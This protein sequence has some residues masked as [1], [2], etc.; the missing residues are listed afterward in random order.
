VLPTKFQLIWA[1]GFREKK[2]NW[3]I[4]NKNC[5]GGHIRTLSD[6]HGIWKSCTGHPIQLSYKV[7][8]ESTYGRFC[9]KLPRLVQIGK[10]TWL[11]WEILA[12]DWLEF[13][14]H[15]NSE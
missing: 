2:I 5:Y 9:I 4:T 1:N 3:S 11:P 8:V 14:I 15:N 12:S 10:Q 7:T 13:F 6:W